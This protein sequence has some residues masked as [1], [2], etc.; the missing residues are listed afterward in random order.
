MHKR[1]IL[2]VGS[3]RH[4]G[5]SCSFLSTNGCVYFAY[6]PMPVIRNVSQVHSLC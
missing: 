3:K 5:S 1:S 6:R 2:S 4:L